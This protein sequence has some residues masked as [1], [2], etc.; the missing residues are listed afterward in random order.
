[1]VRSNRSCVSD[2]YQYVVIAR[3]WLVCTRIERSYHLPNTP[4]HL[5]RPKAPKNTSQNTLDIPLIPPG[6]SRQH[7]TSPDSTRQPQTAPTTASHP[8]SDFLECLRMSGDVFW[9]QLMSLTCLEP[10]GVSE[11]LS[12][13]IW[14]IFRY[15]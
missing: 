1:M 2:L 13:C 9:C 15:T 11:D 14:V 10:S 6:S 8:P 4:K 12:G 3:S 5:S 7:K